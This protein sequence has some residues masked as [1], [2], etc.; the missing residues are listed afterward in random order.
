MSFSFPKRNLQIFTKYL[1]VENSSLKMCFCISNV[2]ASTYGLY[3]RNNLLVVIFQHDT[4]LVLLYQFFL[5]DRTC[6]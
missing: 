3:L 2:S 4:F 5:A 6:K 1:E